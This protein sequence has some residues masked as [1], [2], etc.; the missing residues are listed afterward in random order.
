MKRT[1]ERS[2]ILVLLVSVLLLGGCGQQEQGGQPKVATVGFT[3]PDFTLVDTKNRTWTLSELK[4]KVVFINFWATWCPP[5]R[6]ELP[7]MQ[8]LFM[9]MPGDKFKML[10]ILSNDEPTFAEKMAEDTG[11]TFP[12]MDDPDSSVG[13]AYG[14]TGV[15]ETFIVD[16]EGIL[17]EKFIGPR[18]WSS[19]EARQMLYKYIKQ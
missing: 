5:C 1:A 8:E 3:A 14:L 15:P 11:C 12:V 4:G 9:S 18:H 2:I 13:K 19:P 7:S 6:Q 16:K 10:S 17:R